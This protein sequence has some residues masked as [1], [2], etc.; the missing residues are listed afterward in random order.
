MTGNRFVRGVASQH[1]LERKDRFSLSSCTNDWTPWLS[2]RAP[3]RVQPQ[4]KTK[5]STPAEESRWFTNIPLCNVEGTHPLIWQVSSYLATK[6]SCKS[7]GPM[8]CQWG[9]RE[10]CK[11]LQSPRFKYWLA[12]GSTLRSWHLQVRQ[13][14]DRRCRIMP[15]ANFVCDF[16]WITPNFRE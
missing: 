14:W 6:Y 9:Y 1:I 13:F 3:R 5:T 4:W 10:L 8:L 16:H 2:P 12:D 7:F 15:F 11:Y